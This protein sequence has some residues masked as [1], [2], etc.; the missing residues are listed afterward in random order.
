M[1]AT[2]LIFTYLSGMAFGFVW[3]DIPQKRPTYVAAA[4][5]VILAWPL[6]LLIIAVHRFARWLNGE[7]V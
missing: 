1:I 5:L 6:S 7:G 2:A 3:L 4:A